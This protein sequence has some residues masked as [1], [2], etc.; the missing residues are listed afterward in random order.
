MFFGIL[1]LEIMTNSQFLLFILEFGFL[2]KRASSD[3]NVQKPHRKM[4]MHYGLNM[5]DRLTHEMKICYTTMLKTSWQVNPTHLITAY[6][7]RRK[8][9]QKHWFA[10]IFNAH[11]DLDHHTWP[12]PTYMTLIHMHDLD[13]HTWPSLTYM[14]FTNIHDRDHHALPSSTYM[15]FTKLHDLPKITCLSPTYMTLTNIYDL[16]QHTWPSPTYVT[17]TNIHDLHKHTWPSQTYMTFT[18]IHDLYH[19]KEPMCYADLAQQLV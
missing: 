6:L 13:H 11:D 7:R 12:S 18:I 14:T 1:F 9:N 8:S 19:Y 16:H 15:T 4:F 2:S 3:F 17:F 10:I 5:L